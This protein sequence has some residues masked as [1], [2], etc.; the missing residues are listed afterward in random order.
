MVEVEGVAQGA[1]DGVGA[2][3]RRVERGQELRAPRASPGDHGVRHGLQD[4]GF[5]L[6]PRPLDL[7]G[8][9]GRRSQPDQKHGLDRETR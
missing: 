1:D 4:G 8:G 7:A 9:H 2:V 6:E 3:V 5:E